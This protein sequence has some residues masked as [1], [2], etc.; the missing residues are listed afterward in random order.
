[1]MA[2]YG[3]KNEYFVNSKNKELI[4]SD[5]FK[6]L[7]AKEIS[8][9]LNIT[10]KEVKYY[11]KDFDPILYSQ[12]E[13][14]CKI[15]QGEYD[16][17]S[18]GFPKTLLNGD[19]NLYNSIIH[20]TEDHILTSKKIT[21]RIYRIINDYDKDYIN[22][23]IHCKEPLKFYTYRM[24]YGNSEANIC[25]NCIMTHSKFGVS[26]ISQK[27]FGSIYSNLVIGP[28]DFCKYSDLNGEHII[29]I[30]RSIVNKIPKKFHEHLN[31]HKYLIDFVLNNKII[32][33]DGIYWHKNDIKDVARDEYLMES[34]FEIFRVKEE[35][36]YNFPDRV[37]KEC[38]DFLKQ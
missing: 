37:L 22:V 7:S 5:E 13:V 6:F 14:K 4:L 15:S 20:L 21:E 9:K 17:D 27:L 23:C 11:K 3:I 8:D 32:E 34:G 38:M 18:R 29:T 16:L 2:H 35:D 33:F 31:K 12:E 24:G 25:K 30:D 28:K 10:I 1:L 36:Y 26:M 19:I